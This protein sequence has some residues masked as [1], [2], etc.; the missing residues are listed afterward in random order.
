MAESLSIPA[1]ESETVEFKEQWSDTAKSDFCAFANTSGGTV[2]FGINDDGNIVGVEKPDEVERAIISV[3]RFAMKPSCTS[4]CRVQRLE[5]EG[6]IIMA[7]H[8]LEGGSGPYWVSVS[9]KNGGK[10]R[11]CFMRQGS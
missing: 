5:V 9:K 3:F 8:V 1:A 6:K 10:E 11:K 4:L 7:A 2:Y